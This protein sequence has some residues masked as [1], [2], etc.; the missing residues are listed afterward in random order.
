MSCNENIKK[1]IEEAGYKVVNVLNVWSN[2]KVVR[3]YVGQNEKSVWHNPRDGYRKM[4]AIL[5]EE[6]TK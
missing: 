1:A 5:I 4:L 2:G 6:E 3:R